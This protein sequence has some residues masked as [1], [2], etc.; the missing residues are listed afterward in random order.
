MCEA[1]VNELTRNRKA[2]AGAR[3]MRILDNDFKQLL[4]GSMSWVRKAP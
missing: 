4:L 1:R 3:M 2:L